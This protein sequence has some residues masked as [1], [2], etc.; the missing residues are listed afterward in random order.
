VSRW[1]GHNLKDPER[2]WSKIDAS[3]ICWEWTDSLVRKGYGY[4]RWGGKYRRAHRVVWELLVGT[5]PAGLEPDHLCR[6]RACVNPDHLEFVTH[7]VNTLRGNAPHANNARK[8][9]CP[10]GHE[11]TEANTYIDQGKRR[12]RT[13]LSAKARRRRAERSL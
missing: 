9:H 10:H 13:C 12:C 6:N 1:D 8:T 3:G 4:V 5:L 11:Y 2:V 7:R